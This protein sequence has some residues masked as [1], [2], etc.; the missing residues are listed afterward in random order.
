MSS[1]PFR[2][3]LVALLAS[4]TAQA[5]EGP[6]AGALSDLSK[7]L[8]SNPKNK[9]WQDARWGFR[10]A[11]PMAKSLIFD[12][13][14]DRT[15]YRPLPFSIADFPAAPVAPKILL[16]RGP[17]IAS[18]KPKSAFLPVIEP[19][20]EKLE[21]ALEQA[22]RADAPVKQP[23][24]ALAA[25]PAAAPAPAPAAVPQKTA[26]T[27]VASAQQAPKK[28]SKRKPIRFELGDARLIVVSEDGF[29]G[30]EKAQ[31]VEGAVIEWVGPGSGLRSRTDAAGSARVPY[32]LAL[33]ARFLVRA[34]GYLPATGYA[35]AGL[36]QTIVLIRED[37]LPAIIKSLGITPEPSK[38]LVFGKVLGKNGK[39]I[40]GVTVDANVTKPFRSYY[41]MGSFGLFH[42][43]ANAT[44][45][46]GDF[47]VTGIDNGIQ[48]LMPTLNMGKLP[49]VDDEE[50][51]TMREWPASII[52]F[53]GLPQVV[54]VTISERA[55][56][57]V[58]SQVMDAFGMERPESP[59]HVTVGG[60]RGVHIP[61]DDGDLKIADLS[62]RGSVDL[63][64]VRSQGYL[65][66]WLNA[67]PRAVTFPTAISLFTWSQ[68]E[69][70]FGR[71]NLSVN[72]SRGLV[73]GHLGLEH[74]RNPVEVSVFD[75][76][77]RRN[78][79]AK[80]Y[81]FDSEN[82]IRSS[83]QATD[84]N[85]QSFAAANLG[86]GE[87]HLVAKDAKSGEGLSMQVIRV[88]S[89]TVTQVEF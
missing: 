64:E 29:L 56:S 8:L 37:R 78:S 42:N 13:V 53:S 41:S 73:M 40:A 87:W 57:P 83:M 7:A 67:L 54:T 81:Y 4:F 74:Y 82:E 77:G 26:E 61:D 21:K 30:G 20:I 12:Q 89:E 3:S 59:I 76:R 52:D 9:A 88:D 69:R 86:P 15:S 58:E 18:T 10:A 49:S 23:E 65:R 71:D 36:D 28:K 62:L 27:V 22:T 48:Y 6:A 33:S 32:P 60:Q 39:P 79:E 31:A 66:T 84:H 2:A 1:I 43:A 51:S 34:P 17:T 55:N 85:V 5:A 19:R 63:V 47:L 45:P 25:V 24:P 80:V 35:V 68:M 75:G 16:E 44:G 38:R 14:S 50:P 70:L 72:F 11:H 46:Q